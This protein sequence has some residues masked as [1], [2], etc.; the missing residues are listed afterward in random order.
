M[1]VQTIALINFRHRES[2]ARYYNMPP[3]IP[4]P[5]PGGSLQSVGGYDGDSLGM[6]FEGTKGREYMYMHKAYTCTK[7]LEGGY[8]I[9]TETLLFGK[10]GQRPLSSVLPAS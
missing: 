4:L 6:A 3:I 2:V 8:R 1:A 10:V 5:I 9:S 7:S